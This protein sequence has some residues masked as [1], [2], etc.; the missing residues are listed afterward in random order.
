[1]TIILRVLCNTLKFNYIISIKITTNMNIYIYILVLSGKCLSLADT[2]FT[3]HLYTNTKPYLSNV[4]I[5][6]LI[7]QN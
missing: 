4:V 3:T 5:F 7:E 2:S 6:S 1:M